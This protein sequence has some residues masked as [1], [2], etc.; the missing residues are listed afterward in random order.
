MKIHNR[1]DFEIKNTAG[2]VVKTA[3]AENIVLDSLFERL[4]NGYTYFSYIH[5]GSGT[6]EPLPTDTALTAFFGGRFATL[7]GLSADWDNMIFSARKTIELAANEYVSCTF[8]EVG[9]A[10]SNDSG[11]VTKAL[12]RDENGNPVTIS[13]T[14]TEIMTIHATVYADFSEFEK[15]GIHIARQTSYLSYS[16]SFVSKSFLPNIVSNALGLYNNIICS[17]GT[18]YNSVNITTSGNSMKTHANT[19]TTSGRTITLTCE[20]VGTEQYNNVALK[21]AQLEYDGSVYMDLPNTNFIQPKIENEIIGTGDGT[22]TEFNTKFNNI[23]REP[24]PVVKV[25]GVATEVTINYGLPQTGCQCF[26]LNDYP[27]QYS[28]DDQNCLVPL[29][30]FANYKHSPPGWAIAENIYYDTDVRITY[31]GLSSVDVYVSDDKEVWTKVNGDIP[32][33]YQKARFWKMVKTSGLGRY[34]SYT[35]LNNVKISKPAEIIFETAPP[36]GA[37]I[38]IDYTPNCIA[39]DSDH[40]IRGTQFAFTFNSKG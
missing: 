33:A 39:K 2:D 20:D 24:A 27:R 16:D 19:V 1:F 26:I 31:A 12:I 29:N 4:V 28:T 38:T 36:E 13:K 15:D 5:F 22:K 21:C 10:A 8:A 18:A 35:G 9:I 6:E 11:L 7:T 14:D 37:E 17:S 32:E 34:D 25:D 30:I 3:Y 40:I 23:L